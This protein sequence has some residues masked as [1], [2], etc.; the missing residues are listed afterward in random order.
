MN[1]IIYIICILILLTNCFIIKNN[2]PFAQT[3]YL[4]YDVELNPNILNITFDDWS[5]SPEL[6]QLNNFKNVVFNEAKIKTKLYVSDVYT[7]K[8]SYANKENKVLTLIPDKKIA[9]FIRPKDSIKDMDIKQVK[10]IGY[11]NDI[12]VDILTFILRSCDI[13]VFPKFIKINYDGSIKQTSFKKIDCIFFFTSLS[14]ITVTDKID[15]VT[16]VPNIHKLK[17]FLPYCTIENLDISIHFP[18]KYISDFPVKS[19]VG[20]DLLFYGKQHY[21]LSNQ[22]KRILKKYNNNDIIN[23]YMIFFQFF[24]ITIEENEKFNNH[25]IARKSLPILE[26]FTDIKPK[27]NVHGYF[28]SDSHILTIDNNEIDHIPLVTNDTVKL[29]FQEREEEN[30]SYKFKSPNQLI[31][32]KNRPGSDDEF[33]P[34]YECY[35]HA[36]IAQIGL[37]ISG[38]D[39]SG[40]NKKPKY[41]WD[42]RCETNEECPYYQKNKNYKNYRGGCLDGFCEMPIGQSNISYRTPSSK[43][44]YCHN[45]KDRLD[46]YCCEDQKDK[47]KYPTLI[48]PDYAFELDMFERIYY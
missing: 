26:Q 3:P 48:S 27:H 12:D 11:I 31:R 33:D 24:D 10:T 35:D 4:I 43:K 13:D 15:V 5:Y 40:K 44:P 37:C 23:Y 1:Y 9:I 2:E 41:I 47:D 25:V 36:E 38:Y 22:Y 42:R 28:D 20:I 39:Q 7:Y 21:G 16:Y 18:K 14:N 29:S 46:P 6:K 19:Y 34:R 45:C 8:K 30:G 32:P 17:V